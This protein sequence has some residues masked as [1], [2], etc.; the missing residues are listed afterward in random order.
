[1]VGS[2]NRAAEPKTTPYDIRKRKGSAAGNEEHDALALE[3]PAGNVVNRGEFFHAGVGAVQKYNRHRK[4]RN[5]LS[6]AGFGLLLMVSEEKARRQRSSSFC[7]PVENIPCCRKMHR[8][9]IPNM[10]AVSTVDTGDPAQ[11]SR[12]RASQS[13]RRRPGVEDGIWRCSKNCRPASANRAH[14]AMGSPRIDGTCHRR[15]H[16][17]SA[18]NRL[19]LCVSC[20][21][22]RWQTAWHAPSQ[23][24]FQAVWIFVRISCIGSAGRHRTC[25]FPKPSATGG[26]RSLRTPCSLSHRQPPAAGLLVFGDA[27]RKHQRAKFA[28]RH[29]PIKRRDA[30]ITAALTPLNGRTGQFSMIS[31]LPRQGCVWCLF[32]QGEEPGKTTQV[33]SVLMGDCR[34][35]CRFLS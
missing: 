9:L 8:T 27:P 6:C 31:H 33:S 1:M 5:A 35:C 15:K 20:R 19:S 18:C 13:D 24:M 17:G 21:R 11:P 28:Y 10:I 16:T 4:T 25:L 34:L 14:L 23:V 30:I 3:L 32:L 7:Q 12:V 2:S 22:P 29:S 26:L